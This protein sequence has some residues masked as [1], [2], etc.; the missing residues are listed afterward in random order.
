[1]RSKFAEIAANIQAEPTFDAPVQGDAD[2]TPPAVEAERPAVAEPKTS[3]EVKKGTA[4]DR[5]RARY[6]EHNVGDVQ[7]NARF[8]AWMV[9]ILEDHVAERK[10]EQRL[11]KTRQAPVTRQTVLHEALLEWFAARGIE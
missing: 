7:L 6:E 10:R 5:L 3:R 4:A 1:M 11:S 8:P 9:E 2:L